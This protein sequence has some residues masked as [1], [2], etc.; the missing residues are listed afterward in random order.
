[1]IDK[2]KIS[3]YNQSVCNKTVKGAVASSIRCQESSGR[4]EGI[5]W[6]YVNQRPGAVSYTHLMMD[7]LA[8]TKRKDDSTVLYAKVLKN[9]S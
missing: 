5:I 4:C 6:M 7:I 9:N 1:M 2:M 8:R 3:L